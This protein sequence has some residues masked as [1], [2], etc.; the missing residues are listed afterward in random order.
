MQSQCIVRIVAVVGDK[1]IWQTNFTNIMLTFSTTLLL[2]C[3][4]VK[5]AA[6]LGLATTGGIVNL[7]PMVES[8]SHCYINFTNYDTD[9]LDFSAIT[10]PY[11]HINFLI[12]SH[13][14]RTQKCRSISCEAQFIL[15][16]G[17]FSNKWVAYTHNV[18]RYMDS[19]NSR[20]KKIT[21]MLIYPKYCFVIGPK[22]SSDFYGTGSWRLRLC[23]GERAIPSYLLTYDERQDTLGHARLV[24]NAV[25]FFCAYCAKIRVPTEFGWFP[26]PACAELVDTNVC[27]LHMLAAFSKVMEFEGNIWTTLIDYDQ[28]KRLSNAHNFWNPFSRYGNVNIHTRLLQHLFEGRNASDILKSSDYKPRVYFEVIFRRVDGRPFHK[29][30]LGR[31]PNFYFITPHNVTEITRFLNKEQDMGRQQLIIL[32]VVL[33]PLASVSLTIA[34]IVRLSGDAPFRRTLLHVFK[35]YFNITVSQSNPKDPL[36]RP[37]NSQRIINFWRNI[38]LLWLLATIFLVAHVLSEL[39]SSFMAYKINTT[40]HKRLYD[41]QNLTLYLFVDNSLCD[42]FE[43]KRRWA[44]RRQEKGIARSVCSNSALGGTTMCEFMHRLQL[45]RTF[46][47]RQA[48]GMANPEDMRTNALYGLVFNST[49]SCEKDVAKVLG[50]YKGNLSLA[51]IVRED[52]FKYYRG[53]LQRVITSTNDT[54]RLADNM[55]KEHLETDDLIH[56]EKA[57]FFTG[58]LHPIQNDLPR[59]MGRLL[60]SGIYN[61]WI[62]WERILF[63]KD[64]ARHEKRDVKD[65]D[66]ALQVRSLTFNNSNVFLALAVY[67]TFN[68]VAML[69]YLIESFNH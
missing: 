17:S 49:F 8:F 21:E 14:A 39:P 37:W 9:I 55:N 34:I 40:S 35:W 2:A 48:N 12:V 1:G 47:E 68:A 26:L 54:W 11:S 22:S 5:K 50:Q 38:T 3:F 67:V 30:V 15:T 28:R 51:F 19:R 59:R 57:I 62:K 32:L 58:G 44:I 31:E 20:P 25:Y 23:A 18:Q 65:I 33:V 6:T 45:K 63:S 27:K 36:S 52:E 53:L 43:I 29:L 56:D 64:G 46:Y 13:R 16:D 60:S 24:V 41:I 7:S 69:V 66:G 61:L 4:V 10:V 42:H